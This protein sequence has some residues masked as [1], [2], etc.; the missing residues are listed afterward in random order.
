MILAVQRA[1]ARLGYYHGA[2]DGEPVR[3]PKMPSA[4]FSVLRLPAT[5]EID[6]STLERCES[7]DRRVGNSMQACGSMGFTNRQKLSQMTESIMPKKH[8]LFTLTGSF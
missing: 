7:A 8:H 1:L 4:G 3:K 5:G 2:V 6:S